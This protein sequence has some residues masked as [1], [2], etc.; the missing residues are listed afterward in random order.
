MPCNACGRVSVLIASGGGGGPPSSVRGFLAC[1]SIASVTNTVKLDRPC[2]VGVP[3]RIPSPESTRPSGRV[4]NLAFF[5]LTQKYRA[6]PA[7]ALT[8]NG[9]GTPPA[10]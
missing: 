4:P 3:D 1:L 10:A 5:F 7:A 9:Q 8:S 2:E 6:V